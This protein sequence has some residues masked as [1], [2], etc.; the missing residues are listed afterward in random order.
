[1]NLSQS[2]FIGKP[3]GSASNI[4]ISPMAETVEAE[5]ER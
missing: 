4:D 1:M 3:R 2:L 5:T